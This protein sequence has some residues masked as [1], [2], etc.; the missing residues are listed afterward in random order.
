MIK[1]KE[2]L[3]KTND[4][5]DVNVLV[6]TTTANYDFAG[7]A[8]GL[9]TNKDFIGKYGEFEVKAINVVDEG[10]VLAVEESEVN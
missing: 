9:F 5:L 2:I 10:I 6:Y 8:I 4:V 1:L 3:G 7:S